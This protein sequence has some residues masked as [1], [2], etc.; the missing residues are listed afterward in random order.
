M[1]DNS[2]YKLAGLRGGAGNRPRTDQWTDQY[3]SWLSRMPDGGGRH[4]AI[5]RSLNNYAN[6]KSWA[7]KVRSSWDPDK[8]GGE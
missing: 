3:G 5:T 1:S 2:K 4:A 8:S 6:Y 7:D